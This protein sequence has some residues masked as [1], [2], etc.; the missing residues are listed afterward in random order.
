MMVAIRTVFTL[1]LVGSIGGFGPLG[2]EKSILK[3]GDRTK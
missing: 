3:C 2:E 1:K